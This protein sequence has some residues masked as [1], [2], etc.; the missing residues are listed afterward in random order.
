LEVNKTKKTAKIIK[1]HLLKNNLFRV[2]YVEIKI[3]NPINGIYNRFSLIITFNGTTN[4][5]IREEKAI[6]DPKRK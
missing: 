1:R 6:K 3:H 2:P 5:G 4:V